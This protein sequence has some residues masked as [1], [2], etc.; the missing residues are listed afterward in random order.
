MRS[1]AI[2]LL[3]MAGSTAAGQ[4]N[5]PF[6]FGEDPFISR[7]VD[8]DEL[9]QETFRAVDL[10]GDRIDVTAQGLPSGATLRVREARPWADDDGP[11]AQE[12]RARYREVVVTWR[13]TREQRGS[14]GVVLE[15]ADGQASESVELTFRVEEEWESWFLPGLQYVGYFPADR[16][17]AGSFHGAAFEIVLGSWVHQ[18]EARGP[19]HGRVYVDLALLDPDRAGAARAFAYSLGLDLSV[20]RNPWRQYLIPIFG[21]EVGGFHQRQAGSLFMTTP[22]LGAH[23]FSARN[24][25]VTVTGGYVFS[26]RDIDVF[27]GWRVRAGLNAVLW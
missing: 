10:D 19:S 23:L 20:E 17:A 24:I 18:T 7:T 12:A 1:F 2:H 5:P 15:V 14:H 13:P 8:V 3:A 22:F 9:Y 4:N 26:G 25:F 27:G 16:E 11:A 6:L 21:V